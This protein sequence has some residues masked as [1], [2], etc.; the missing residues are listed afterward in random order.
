MGV[1]VHNFVRV[2]QVFYHAFPFVFPIIINY[3]FFL[4]VGLQVQAHTNGIGLGVNAGHGLN[5]ENLPLL[6]IVPHMVELNIGHALISDALFLS[7]RE[8]VLEFRAAC[9]R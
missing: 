2:V 6:H 1:G 9:H 7:L 4:F 3:R 8:A 5:L